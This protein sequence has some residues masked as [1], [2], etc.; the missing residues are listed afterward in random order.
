M[1]AHVLFA[2]GTTFVAAV[3]ACSS[4]NPSVTAPPP[5]TL[6]R[7]QL[8]DPATCKGCHPDAYR[9]WSGSMHA[10]A[11]DDP[12]F[13]AMNARGQR[14][15]QGALGTFCVGCHAPMAVRDGATKDGLDLDALPA[16]LKGVT[17]YF[18]HTV[19][20][21]EGA[22]NAPL[23]LA[24]D[25]VMRGGIRDPAATG[26][27][28]SAHS[29]LLDRDHDESA[30]MCGACH[31]ITNGH[32]AAL[33]RTFAEWQA[34]VFSHPGGATCSQCHM[35]QSKDARPI[36]TPS[37]SPPRRAHG[38]GFPGVDVTLTPGFPEEAAQRTAVEGLL[39]TTLQ[40]AL[41]VKSI[42]DASAVRVLVDNVAAG[43][44]WPSGAS[45]DRRAFFE[46]I[47]EKAGQRIYSSGVVEGGTPVTSLLATDPDLWL[48]RDCIS[49]AAG[50]P[51][52]MFWEAERIE[53]RQ[54]PAQV[55]FDALDPRF[56]QTHVVQSYPRSG[57]TF[58][59][60]PD[61]VTLR[62][63]MQPIGLDVLDDLVASGDLAADV[64]ARM[65]TFDVG[66]TLVWT[67]DAANLT[68]LEDRVPVAC[69]T[70]TNFNVEA[71]KTPAPPAGRC[72]G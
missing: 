15:T 55:T 30:R 37:G 62:V 19:D 8:M 51:V 18:C 67:K 41:C 5:T 45:Q 64:R 29:P 14:E 68:Y 69:V 24:E 11:A 49:D 12:V 43:H 25:S 20:R 7:E 2:T 1:R 26:A 47:A 28:G 50:K 39:G 32:G 17:C 22:H 42:G 40:T 16:R 33:E 34:S 56:Y 66:E 70:R 9:E 27:H 48:L 61:R 3:V 65:P 4:S 21:V 63:R 54:L 38:H 53:P 72:G 59:G 10:Y 13:R 58:A 46:V 60:V 57:S 35:E 23:H 6:S 31:D 36:A 52:H 71:D 44:A